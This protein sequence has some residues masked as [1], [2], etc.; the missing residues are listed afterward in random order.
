MLC[1][2]KMRDGVLAGAPKDW[3]IEVPDDLY[4]A[5]MAQYGKFTPSAISNSEINRLTFIGEKS[6][7]VHQEY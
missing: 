4:M 6:G 5:H 3:V 1:I 2:I 7:L